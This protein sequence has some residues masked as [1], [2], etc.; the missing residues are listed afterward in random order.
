MLKNTRIYALNH[1]FEFIHPFSDGN[2]RT[3]HL[4]QSLI[5]ERLNPLFEH[6]PVENAKCIAILSAS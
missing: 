1:E 2:G 6:L 4:W 3:E 5:L